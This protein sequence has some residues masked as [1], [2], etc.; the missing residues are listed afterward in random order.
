M[1]TMLPKNEAESLS[2]RCTQ[3]VSYTIAPVRL[4]TRNRR[5]RN[6]HSLPILHAPPERGENTTTSWKLVAATNASTTTAA[7]ADR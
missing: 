1:I 2:A 4:I 5:R 7:A 6:C 3:R